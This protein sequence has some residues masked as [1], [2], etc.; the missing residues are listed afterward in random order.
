MPKKTVTVVASILAVAI[1]VA[2]LGN[3]AIHIGE[4]PL[5]IIV[6]G[7]LGLML[8]DYIDTIRTNFRANNNGGNGSSPERRP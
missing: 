5:M 4:I 8:W 1:A 7:V 2:F 3:L 6:F